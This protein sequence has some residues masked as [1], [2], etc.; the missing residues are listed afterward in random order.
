MKDISPTPSPA[1]ITADPA[2]DPKL[3]DDPRL[4]S[5]SAAR[6][7]D[8]IAAAIAP[9]TPPHTQ[10]LEIGSGSG[11]HV[12]HFAARMP[13]VRWTPSDPDPAARRSIAAWTT[14]AKLSNVEAPLCIDATA[15]TWPVTAGYALVL[16]IN[17]I[18]IAPW[19][20]A[21]GLFA[22]AARV[23]TTEGRLA[24]YGPFHKDGAPTSESNAA[25]DASLRARNPDWG[26]R[27][28][29]ALTRLAQTNGL[30][31]TSE[32]PMPANNKI[33]VYARR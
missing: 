9:I 25:F 4:V 22:G 13:W 29:E 26:V 16:S 33:L 28:I 1:A 30:I 21:E 23:L 5:P 2:T 12:T 6:N 32:T 3:D 27:D 14:H 31:Q 7:R 11:E 24:L 17:M 20:A 19:S 10:V 8:V 15:Q 18:H